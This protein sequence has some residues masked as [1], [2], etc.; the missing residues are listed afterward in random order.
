[1][2][3]EPILVYEAGRGQALRETGPAVRQY[4]LAGLL[5]E[6]RHFGGKIAVHDLGR[7]PAIRTC[8]ARLGRRPGTRF[9]CSP[10]VAQ[11]VRR[12]ASVEVQFILPRENGLWN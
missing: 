8:G 11:R 10:G 9:G 6:P 2:H 1:M 5:L 3:E 7:C 12:A 4:V